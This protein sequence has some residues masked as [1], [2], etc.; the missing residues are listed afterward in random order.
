MNELAPELRF[1]MGGG[2]YLS[3]GYWRQGYRMIGGRSAGTDMGGGHPP[4]RGAYG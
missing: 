3:N 1:V 2:V 4:E